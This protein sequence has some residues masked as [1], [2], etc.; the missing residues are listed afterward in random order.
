MNFL[1][2]GLLTFR[3]QYCFGYWLFFFFLILQVSFFVSFKSFVMTSILIL[4][5]ID[6][7]E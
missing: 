6:V 5:E 4:V 2:F 1:C 7:I 3:L